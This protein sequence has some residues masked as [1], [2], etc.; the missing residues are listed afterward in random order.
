MGP[1]MGPPPGSATDKLKE[2]KPKS[3]K[4]V[5]GYLRR[6]VSKFFYRLFYIFRLVW[7]ARP[8]ILFVM[9]FMAI[10]NGV[11]PVISA[12]ISRELL[13]RLAESYG[14]GEALLRGVM[15]LLF[16]YF[17]YMF[18][19][20]LVS[21]ISSILTNIA[22]ELVVNH[23][24]VKIMNKAKTVDLSGYDRPEFCEKLENASRE[25]GHRPIHILNAN[26]S[27]ISTAISMVSFIVILW[28]VRK[29]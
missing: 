23:V 26:F 29:R 4:E 22:G 21:R 18:F 15:V 17:G 12:L 3:L 20:Q 13:N 27:I 1:M 5:P 11:M 10:F 16:V 7:E 28:A 25:A 24:N 14:G 6:T 19:T 2:P 8:W 9:M